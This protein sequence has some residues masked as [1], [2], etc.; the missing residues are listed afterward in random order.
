MEAMNSNTNFRNLDSLSDAGR[1]EADSRSTAGP[2]DEVRI[3]EPA[4]ASGLTAVHHAVTTRVEELREQG[5][6][7]LG[8]VR[9]AVD[10]KVAELTP[11]V[12]AVQKAVKEKLEAVRRDVRSHLED[13]KS[14]IDDRVATVDNRLTML[15]EQL[16]R[17]VVAARAE[18]RDRVTSMESSVRNGLGQ[19]EQDVRSNPMKWA[20]ISAGAGIG[21]GLVSRWMHHRR[22]HRLGMPSIIVIESA[23]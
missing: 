7:K 4:K 17:R 3:I 12:A 20:G 18:V 19:V 16:D 13:A 22:S 10:G 15:K 11:R 1:F 5:A 6:Q 2:R 14:H 23:C 8:E 21:I 9:R